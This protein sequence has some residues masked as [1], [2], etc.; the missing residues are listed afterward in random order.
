MVDDPSTG[1]PFLALQPKQSVSKQHLSQRVLPQFPEGAARIHQDLL[2]DVGFGYGKPRFRPEPEQERLAVKPRP[3]V[4]VREDSGDDAVPE[5]EGLG[6]S[7]GDQTADLARVPDD[8][9]V[10]WST[11][12]LAREEPLCSPWNPE[13]CV[14]EFEEQDDDDDV[15]KKKKKKMSLHCA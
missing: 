7:F 2:D 9:A 3:L 15:S 5:R 6:L 12:A 11:Y 13:D 14:Y 8:G 1:S 4:V 10:S